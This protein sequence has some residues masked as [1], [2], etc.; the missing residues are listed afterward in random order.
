MLDAAALNS[1]IL[2]KIKNPLEFEA[3]EFRMRRK[4]MECLA[5]RLIT[6]NVNDRIRN[7]SVNNF[8]GLKIELIQTFEKLGFKINKQHKRRLTAEVEKKMQD[9]N[10][11]TKSV[12]KIKV[13]QNMVIAALIVKLIF[14][15]N[16]VKL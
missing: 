5:I 16:T 13:K 7:A 6:L 10:V 8:S 14:A 11:F 4:L 3:D 2:F 9:M 1:F 15:P 12:E